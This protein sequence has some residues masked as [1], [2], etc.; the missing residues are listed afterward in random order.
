MSAN[1]P[2]SVSILAT[3]ESSASTLFGL[4]DILSTVGVGWE[5]FVTGEPCRPAYDVKVVTADGKSVQCGHA[6]V[7]PD[8]SVDDAR[9]TDIA[10]VSSFVSPGQ[11]L[12]THDPRECAWLTHL[13][14]NGSTIGSVCTGAGL[15]AASGLLNNLEATTHW[16]FDDLYRI[17]YPEVIWKVDKTLCCSGED[18]RIV[19]AGGT[20]SWQELAIHLIIRYCG[21]ETANQAAKF[22]VIPDRGQS[23]TPYAVNYVRSPH[24]DNLIQDCQSWIAERFQ[25]ANPISAMVDYTAL[26]Q[27]TFARRFKKATGKRPMDYI[28]G[29]RIERAKQLIESTEQAIDEVGRDVGY[30]DPASFR[31]IFK[32][33][34]QITPSE[35]RI[36]FAY[37][38][39]ER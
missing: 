36:K 12:R 27:T 32:R 37:T 6:K 35:Y 21:L 25:E 34:V 26:P 20:T 31:R 1:T 8:G 24:K 39:F 14:Q 33:F 29:L 22:W 10:I 7:S 28:H 13:Y 5:Q 18:D 11:M 9:D 38:R 23:Q 17:T 3:P 4:V 30:E 19:T 15:L 16:F 2:L